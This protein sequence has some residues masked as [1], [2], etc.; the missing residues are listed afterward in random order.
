MNAESPNGLSYVKFTVGD[1]APAIRQRT[2]RMAMLFVDA[3]AGRYIVL[4]FY[5][6][7][8]DPRGRAAIEAVLRHRN[9]FDDKRASFFAVS[10]DPQDETEARVREYDPGIRVLWDFDASVSRQCG[11][12]P[13]EQAVQPELSLLRRTWVIIDPTWHVLATFP[14]ASDETDQSVFDFLDSLPPPDQYGGIEIPAPI[15]I[16]PNVF[17]PELCRQLIPTRR[18]ADSSG[19][20]KSP[21]K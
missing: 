18:V 21:A 19:I 10:I 6:S 8:A 2:A 15:L 11:V 5:G 20:P 16:L 13:H 3:I 9:R 14:F 1:P 12:F 7:A 4:C 17:E